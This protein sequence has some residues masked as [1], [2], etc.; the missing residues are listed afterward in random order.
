MVIVS[1]S[2]RSVICS[3]TNSKSRENEDDSRGGYSIVTER[4]T[5]DAAQSASDESDEDRHRNSAS[6]VSRSKEHHKDLALV[7]ARIHGALVDRVEPKILE[8][9]STE[10]TNDHVEDRTAERE[11]AEYSAHAESQGAARGQ[12]IDRTASE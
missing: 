8:S 11:P 7:Y 1:S 12:R 10:T 2:L 4:M 9:A 5:R 3:L 6:L